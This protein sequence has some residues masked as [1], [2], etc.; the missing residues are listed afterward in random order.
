[1]R[2]VNLINSIIHFKIVNLV[3]ML[4]SSILFDSM[5]SAS[6][7]CLIIFSDFIRFA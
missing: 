5:K 3:L 4:I 1:M 7:N 6:F 2:T